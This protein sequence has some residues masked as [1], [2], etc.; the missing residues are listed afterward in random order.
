MIRTCA[1]ATFRSPTILTWRHAQAQRSFRC[2]QWRR[3]EA[4][5][6]GDPRLDDFGRKITDE[7]AEMRE[8][9]GKIYSLVLQLE[10]VLTK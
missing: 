1:R 7:F 5:A 8:K 2:T 4:Q 6:K 10:Q 9:Y 3:E